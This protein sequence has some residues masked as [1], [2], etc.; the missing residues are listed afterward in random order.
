MSL[1]KNGRRLRSDTPPLVGLLTLIFECQLS[2]GVMS[3]P[4]K[5]ILFVFNQAINTQVIAKKRL[6]K[7]SY[8]LSLEKRVEQ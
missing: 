3:P 7:G 5:Y 4:V 8:F 6:R 2:K 1:A